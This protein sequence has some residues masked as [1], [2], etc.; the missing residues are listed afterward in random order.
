MDLIIDECTQEC[1]H[2]IIMDDDLALAVRPNLPTEPTM[3]T[4][5]TEPYFNSMVRELCSLLSPVTPLVSTQYRQF[6]QGKYDRYQHNQR[7]SMI[8]AMD[9]KFFRKNKEFRFYNGS[10]LDFMSDYHFFLNLLLHGYPNLCINKYTKDDQPNREGGESAKRKLPIFN[11]A[12]RQFAA[13]Y[14]SYVKVRTKQDKGHWA[15]GMLGV[16]IQAAKAYRDSSK[17]LD[18]V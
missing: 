8:W 6:C 13:M 11:K 7:I 3:F 18:R 2:L 14:P 10:N 12:V 15:D 4:P 16:T 9:A 5:M 1:E 17:A